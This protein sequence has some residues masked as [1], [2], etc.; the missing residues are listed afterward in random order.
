LITEH[1][2]VITMGRGAAPEN[3]LVKP[4]ELVKK[5]VDLFEIERGGDITFHGPGQA[6]LYPIIDLRNRGCDMHRYLRDIERF[7]ID[8]LEE[9]GLDAETK[10]G[11]T[12][13]WVDDKKIGAI[14]VAV[15]RWISYH[16]LS[17]NV[18]T[19]LDYYNMIIPC[20]ITEYEVGSISGLLDEVINMDEIYELLVRH[21]VIHF[22]YELMIADMEDEALTDTEGK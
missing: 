22:D 13:I 7:V 12:G 15:S 3:L 6:V 20:G 10:E 21:F 18:N 5:G 8:A 16:G 9:L 2:P 14:G 4:D 1:E 11:M 17:L 19:N